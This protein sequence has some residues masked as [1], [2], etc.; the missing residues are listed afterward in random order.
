[1]TTIRRVVFTGDVLRPA[2]TLPT[3]GTREEEFRSAQAENIAWFHRLCGGLVAE[4]TGLPSERVSWREFDV[5]GVYAAWEVEPSWRGWAAIADSDLAPSSAIALFEAA[6]ADAVVIGFEMSETAKRILSHLGIPFLD[7]SIH[8]IR[9]MED[10]FFAIQTNDEGVFAALLPHHAASSRFHGAAGI[11]AAS[12][13]KFFPRLRIRSPTL[14][15]GQTR[16]DR[17]LIRDGEVLDLS[18]FPERVR[19][20]AGPTGVISYRPHPYESGDFGLLATGA[21]FTALRLMREN[22]YALMAAEEVT[23]VLG[24]S[25]SVLFEAPYFGRAADWLLGSPFDI[26]DR[27]EDAIPGQ[28]LSILDGGF[29]VDFWRGALAPLMPVTATDGERWR[30]PPNALRTSLRNFWGYNE[31]TTDFWTRLAGTHLVTP[32]S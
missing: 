12:A 20:A 23:T 6:Y 4:A 30:R 14:V 31:M 29:D 9:F 7:V 17:S 19:G 28:H 11:V 8:P 2:D 15:I 25:S 21:P 3:P 22:V 10:V 1:M 5:R 16:V 27:A 26:P 32:P 18:H 13:V 24:L